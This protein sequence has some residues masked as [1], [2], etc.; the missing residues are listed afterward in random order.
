VRGSSIFRTAGVVVECRCESRSL[1]PFLSRCRIR[2]TAAR[3]VSYRPAFFVFREKCSANAADGMLAIAWRP[4]CGTPL[5]RSAGTV[6]C[7]GLGLDAGIALSPFPE[8]A[9]RA[10]RAGFAAAGSPRC[11]PSG[12]DGRCAGAGTWLPQCRYLVTETEAM[13]NSSIPSAEGPAHRPSFHFRR[14]SWLLP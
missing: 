11:L 2:M 13:L 3:L 10:R 5:A 9:H 14:C 4:P 7:V 12:V 8:A 1:T 6:G